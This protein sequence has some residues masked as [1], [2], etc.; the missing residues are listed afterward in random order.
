MLN[1]HN[2]ASNF[3]NGKLSNT[4]LKVFYTNCDVLTNTKISELEHYVKTDSPDIIALTE[5]LPKRSLFTIE[6]VN[7][8]M[9]GYDI[10]GTGFMHGRGTILYI[11]SSLNATQVNIDSQF[12][13]SVWCKIKL[14]NDDNLVIGCVYKSPS[15]TA[16]NFN[17]LTKT[18]KKIT[19]LNSSHLLI[20]GDFNFKEIN[21]EN[22][23]TTVGE[24]HMATQFLECIKDCFLFQHVQQPTRLRAGNIPSILDLVL[25]NEEDMLENIDYLPGL[26]LS[27]HLVL[28]CVFNCYID[29]NSNIS[30]RLN[31]HKGNYGAI[32]NELSQLQWGEL[33]GGMSLSDSWDC[34]TEN[35]SKLIEQH[36]PEGKALPATGRRGRLFNCTCKEAINRKHTKWKKYQYCKTDHNYAL[37]KQARNEVKNVL[38]KATYNHE[39]DLAAKIK[40]DSKLFWKYTRSKTKTKFVINKLEKSNG[41]LTTDDQES[42][43]VLNEYFASVFED[44]SMRNIPS[45]DAK[46]C[47]EQLISIEINEIKIEKAIDKLKPSKSQGPDNLHPKL[48]KE[49]KKSLLKPLNIIFN[50]SLEESKIPSVWKTANVSAIFKKGS[51]QKPE[52]YRPISL[53]SVPGKL[54]ERLVRNEIVRHMTENNFFNPNQHGFMKG[55]SC[56]TQLLEFLEDISEAI[57]NGDDVDVIYLDFCKAFDKVPHNR[58]LVKL[59]SYGITGKVYSWIKEFLS[60]RTQRVVIN[61][62]KS[63]W[64]NVKSG[65]PQGSV[66]GPILFLVY[67]NDL[68]NTVTCLIK[69]FAD[70]SK[71][72]SKVNNQMQA[73]TLQQNLNSAE[74]W[75]N[76][77][78][79]YFNAKKCKHLHIGKKDSGYQ[80]KMRN[81]DNEI[82]L[83]KVSSETDLGVIID[84][85]LNFSKHASKK[86]A[87]ANRNVGIIFRTFTFMD[88]EIFLNLYKS[89]VRPHLEYASSV[90]SPVFKK[91]K[92]AIEN[93]QRRA[94]RL[95][96]SLKDM[97]YEQRLKTLGLPSLEYRRE[98]ADM[99]QTFKILQEI[100]LIDK[101]KIFTMSTYTRTRGH[102][103]KI[104]KRRSRLISRANVFSNRIVNSWNNLPELVVMAPSLNAFKSRLNTHWKHHPSKFTPT[105]Y[106]ITDTT[107]I[108]SRRNN[109][110]IEARQPD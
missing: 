50:K 49:T 92:I 98:R 37:Y 102:S 11:K 88:K 68:P 26:G 94:T 76:E 77:W 63:E 25:T 16:N 78:Q 97:S 72:Y 2:P 99:V 93:V 1:V 79:M 20:M 45:L 105:C 73:E 108:A 59:H 65:I 91:D 29:T 107:V 43:N 87:I 67:I 101:E 28:Q 5:V 8:E 58:L 22:Y 103:R 89:I 13:E 32:D 12:E 53:T 61:G 7:Y 85:N 4:G 54:L 110:S 46:Q 18:L 90:W 70:D 66:L 56:T 100:D 41:E 64:R 86:V 84:S 6:L 40:T 51:K 82:T 81:N 3:R 21:W 31:F 19:E 106:T 24:L 23:M 83:E 69:L 62:K 96:N 47:I 80:Y 57:D 52:N 34:L 109:A 27:D 95:V 36:V 17:N 15:C 44:E 38:R 55:K 33:M 14:R 9:E 10:F 75:A 35:L 48:I 60:D 71:L 74:T 30:S 39:K 104:F 42:A